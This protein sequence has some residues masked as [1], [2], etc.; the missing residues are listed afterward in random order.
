[1]KS[2]FNIPTIYPTPTYTPT[3]LPISPVCAPPHPPFQLKLPVGRSG[4][5]IPT[6]LGHAHIHTF[7]SQ[8][9]DHPTPSNSTKI[10]LLKFQFATD[11][12]NHSL[13]V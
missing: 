5:N 2:Q 4:V 13:V 3:H 9:F 10:N 8:L 6:P 11:K 7:Q 12:G 1:M